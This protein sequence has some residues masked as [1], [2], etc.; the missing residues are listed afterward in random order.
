MARIKGWK[1]IGKKSWENLNAKQRVFV[2]WTYKTSKHNLYDVKLYQQGSI[3]V[4]RN[5]VTE[6]KG[7]EEVMTYMRS[8]PN[9]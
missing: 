8:H 2:E 9:G 4:L 7:L 6:K 3:R 1:K 5:Y